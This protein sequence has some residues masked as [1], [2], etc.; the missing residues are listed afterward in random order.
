MSELG[1]DNKAAPASGMTHRV[2]H[3]LRQYAVISAYLYVCFGALLLYK[4]AI[5]NGQGIS[6]APYGT[7]A[8][9]A[10][11]LGK[12]ILLGEAAGIGDRY[13]KR[14]PIHTI[15]Y[16]AFLFVVMLFVLS[17]IE[18][19]IT[20]VVHGRT[21]A[22]SLAGFLGGSLL[23]VLAICVIMLLILIPYMAFKELDDALGQDRLRQLLFEARAGHRGGSGRAPP[24]D[25]SMPSSGPASQAGTRASDP[26]DAGPAKL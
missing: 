24:Q 1:H 19:V 7:A 9:K 12:F 5:L 4:T 11:I 18:E 26:A 8:I 13:E 14:R 2:V 23:Q 22:A 20:G 3:E 21:V 17:A 15:A 25:G 10:L 16:K 6:Y